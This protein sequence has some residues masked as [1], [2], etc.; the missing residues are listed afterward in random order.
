MSDKIIE[1]N[2]M[3]N[4][5]ERS[6]VIPE[7]EDDYLVKKRKWK[8][9]PLRL[10]GLFLAIQLSKLTIVYGVLYASII[11]GLM[12]NIEHKGVFSILAILLVIKI[13]VFEKKNDSKSNN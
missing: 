3:A 7:A 4:D 8:W 1:D 11:E 9:K 12:I 13:W 10:I 5:P 6:Y 2:R